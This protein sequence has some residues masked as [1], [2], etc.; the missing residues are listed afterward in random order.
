MGQ[1]FQLINIDRRDAQ[2]V[3]KLAE[4]I[5]N[6]QYLPLLQLLL[7]Q[8]SQGDPVIG[9]WVGQRIITAGDYMGVVL[10]SA[11]LKAGSRP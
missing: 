2:Q 3:G 9:A 4:A 6:Y 5:L 8:E 7:R 10:P 1:Y 11:R